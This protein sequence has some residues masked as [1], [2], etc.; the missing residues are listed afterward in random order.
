MFRPF[1]LLVLLLV[2]PATLAGCL[3]PGA[4]I[5][6]PSGRVVSEQGRLLEILHGLPPPPAVDRSAALDRWESFVNTYPKRDWMMPH[7]VEAAA[8][9][10]AELAKAGYTTDVLEFPIK[11]SLG[12]YGP[13]NPPPVDGMAK[14]IRGTKVGA[15]PDHRIALVAHYDTATGT[16][17]GA[18]DDGSG[19]MIELELCRILARIPTNR[20]LDCLFFDAEERGLL[21][22]QK[23]VEAWARHALGNFTYDAAIGFDMT[24]L[25]WPGYTPWKLYAMVGTSAKDH[26]ELE[27]LTDPLHAF[28]DVALRTFVDQGPVPGA[29]QGVAIVDVADRNSDEQNFMRAG[30]PVIRFTGGR[31]PAE[32]PQ[33]HGPLDTPAYVYQFAGGRDNFARGYEFA[34]VASYYAILSLDRLDPWTMQLAS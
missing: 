28:L 9:L 5:G 31:S 15:S 27:E 4:P 29:R 11:A 32:Y 20:T 7:N 16:T 23:Y 30:V 34:L 17:Q 26:P 2:G 8:F 21:A 3:A 6:G 13:V 33:Y 1:A 19:T 25:N 10:A 18:Y 22:S 14:V 24:G 12:S